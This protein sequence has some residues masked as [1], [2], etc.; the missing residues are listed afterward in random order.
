MVARP[1][2]A[3]PVDLEK[4]LFDKTNLTNFSDAVIAIAITLLVLDLKVPD[5]PL[6]NANVLL[7]PGLIEILHSF[8]GFVIGFF[9]I[10][11]Y[12]YAYH[13][14]MKYVERVDKV[15]VILNIL[16]IFFIAFLPFPTSLLSKFLATYIGIVLYAVVIACIS[17]VLFG[18][19]YYAWREGELMVETDEKKMMWMTIEPLVNVCIYL[20]SIPLAF[21]SPFLSIVVWAIAP[22]LY[23]FVSH[24]LFHTPR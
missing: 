18:M 16:F 8:I 21:L 2:G 24:R 22:A 4:T 15:F 17:L 3:G 14:F 10:A 20:A 19:H 9:V 7:I 1:K 11:S 5:I 6:E 13:K 23:N 12:W